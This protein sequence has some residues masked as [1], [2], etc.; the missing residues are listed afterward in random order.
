MRPSY[1]IA[2]EAR[3]PWFPLLRTAGILSYMYCCHRGGR[4]AV[5]VEVAMEGLRNLRRSLLVASSPMHRKTCSQRRPHVV[6][7]FRP[8]KLL[9]RG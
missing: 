8:W 2:R 1:V 3:L 7:W 9:S 5:V 4:S 6:Q